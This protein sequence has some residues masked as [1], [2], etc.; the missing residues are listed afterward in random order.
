MKRQEKRSV[1]NSSR[2]TREISC[3]CARSVCMVVSSR[4]VPNT[5]SFVETG[6]AVTRSRELKPSGGV[7]FV[8]PPPIK[9]R[10]DVRTCLPPAIEVQRLR[11]KFYQV[12]RV[13]ANEWRIRGRRSGEFVPLPAL[14]ASRAF[15]AT[16]RSSVRMSRVVS[17]SNM[18]TSETRLPNQY[19]EPNARATR[20]LECERREMT[21]VRH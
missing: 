1:R 14:G 19:H 10:S 9:P 8:A 20:I 16:F 18:R 2:E 12:S 17:N 6:T 15:P 3:G 4:V 21:E 5:S 7:C 13:A 11:L